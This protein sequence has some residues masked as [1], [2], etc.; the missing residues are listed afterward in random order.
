[1]NATL[2]PAGTLNASLNNKSTLT[3]TLNGSNQKLS[4][5]MT[6]P[7][8]VYVDGTN[9]YEILINKPQIESVELVGNKTFSDLGLESITNSDLMDLLTF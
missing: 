4:G 8:T 1:M 2:K 7:N 9:D 6:V 5:N 3:G